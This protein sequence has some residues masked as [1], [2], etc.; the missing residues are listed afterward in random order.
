MTSKAAK[1]V[2]VGDITE[3]EILDKL[4]FLTKLPAREINIPPVPATP[5][6]DKTRIYLVDVPKAAQTEFRV[7]GVTG[8]KY[9]ATGEYYLA[10]LANFPLGGAFNSRINLN[11]R[12][13]KG[14]TYGARSGFA[15]DK[16]SGTFTFSSG[17]R[18]MSTDSALSEVI[19]E[20]KFYNQ[21]GPSEAELQFMKKSI[22]QSDARNYETGV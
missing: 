15:G 8:L 12:E 20:I 17:I 18:A 13:D 1:L 14:W 4:V 3:I 19:R 21:S 10:T 2:I 22:G 7:G 11:L 16:Y 6:V 5:L 9:D